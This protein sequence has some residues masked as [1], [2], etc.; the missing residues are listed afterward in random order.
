MVI[1]TSFVHVLLLKVMRRRMELWYR[2]PN[3][4]SKADFFGVSF[5]YLL[6][7]K[8]CVVRYIIGFKYC[9]YL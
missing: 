7:D 8:E 9:P 1:E 6:L 2:S 5:F 4:I 3:D